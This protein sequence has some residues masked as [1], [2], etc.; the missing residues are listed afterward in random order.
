MT[1]NDSEISEM[2]EEIMVLSAIYPDCVVCDEDGMGAKVTVQS[3][4]EGVANCELRFVLA[5][6]Y[7]VVIPPLK[8]LELSI[9]GSSIYDE[10]R[11]VMED[12]LK[13]KANNLVERGE[14]AIVTSLLED[15]SRMM[16]VATHSCLLENV[17]DAC[18]SFCYSMRFVDEEPELV[19]HPLIGSLFSMLPPEV[20][21]RVCI[22]ILLLH[23]NDAFFS[24][25]LCDR[26]CATWTPEHCFV[27]LELARHS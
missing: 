17:H 11:Y 2:N 3:L 14:T 21:L 15:L 10:V 25:T 6:E 19:N 24:H 20:I 5:E 13:W 23:I 16:I 9:S 18:A 1:A 22:T 27:S 8:T 12:M 4:T 26:L 7:P